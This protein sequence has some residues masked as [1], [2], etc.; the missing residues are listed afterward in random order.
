MQQPIPQGGPTDPGKLSVR[1]LK[2]QSSIDFIRLLKPKLA[3]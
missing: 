3:K 1:F 2:I